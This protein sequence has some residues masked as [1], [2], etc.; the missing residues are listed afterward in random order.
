MQIY[1]A[2]GCRKK[3][4]RVLRCIQQK[5]GRT[6][7]LPL[8]RIIKPPPCRCSPISNLHDSAG[9]FSVWH[10]CA[11]NVRVYPGGLLLD[12]KTFRNPVLKMWVKKRLL[13]YRAGIRSSKTAFWMRRV[14]RAAARVNPVPAKSSFTKTFCSA[15]MKTHAMRV[16]GETAFPVSGARCTGGVIRPP[17]PRRAP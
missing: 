11:S 1:A 5:N 3:M 7:T 2:N 6:C 15:C 8:L 4:H 16:F 13:S 9:G 10:V 14:H 17:R 12:A